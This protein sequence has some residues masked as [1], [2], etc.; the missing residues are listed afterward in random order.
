MKKFSTWFLLALVSA[1]GAQTAAAAPIPAPG[2]DSVRQVHQWIEAKD[3]PRAVRELNAGLAKGYPEVA[4]LGGAMYEEGTCLKRDWNRAVHFYVMAN[5]GGQRAAPHRL[6]S[7][8]ASAA[9]GTDMAAAL[10]WANRRGNSAGSACVVS[11]AAR[12]DPDRFVAEL[13]TWSPSRL[14]ACNYIAGVMSTL[15][16]DLEYP[17]TAKMFAVRGKVHVRFLP[18]MPRLDVTTT[19][20]ETLE[21]MGVFNADTLRD[22]SAKPV[23]SAFEA[24]VRK[25]AERALKRYPQP[26][27]IDPAATAEMDLIFDIG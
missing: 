24:E 17:D 15:A 23:T 27:K 5:E 26:A 4:L 11:D 12:T 19:G 21:V 13:Q 7:G 14:A 16:G 10:W 2:T 20:T 8:Y 9:G 1:H 22:R 6:A 3:C 25:L 18:W